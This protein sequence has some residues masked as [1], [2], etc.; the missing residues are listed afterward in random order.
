MNDSSLL[1]ATSAR[2]SSSY[3]VKRFLLI[4]IGMSAVVL[5]IA[6]AVPHQRARAVITETTNYVGDEKL[7]VMF[8]RDD[9]RPLALASADFDEDGTP[10]LVGGYGVG[11]Q[12]AVV[13]YRGNADAIYP[14]STEA[15]KR[16]A[17]GS[18]TDAPFLSPGSIFAVETAVDFLGAGD[19]DA[20]GHW[21]VVAATRGANVLRWLPG[22]GR[23]GFGE[24][25]KV[26]LAGGVTALIANDINRVDGLTDVV[27][28]TAGRRGAQALVFEN[29]NGAFN[30]EPEIINFPAPAASFACG[31]LDDEYTTDIAIAAGNNL[32][33]VYG[34]D[35]KLSLDAAARASVGAA[36]MGRREFPT[37]IKSLSIGAFTGGVR[38]DIAVLNGDGEVQILS[39][40]SGVEDNPEAMDNLSAWRTTSFA[41]G[42]GVANL[43]R[44]RV[45]GAAVDNLI[46]PDELNHQVSVLGFGELKT[47]RDGNNVAPVDVVRQSI[48]TIKLDNS[49]SA[50]LAMRLNTDALDDLVFLQSGRSAPT[51][52]LTNDAGSNAGS[53]AESVDDNQS[54]LSLR[55]GVGDVKSSFVVAAKDVD[56]PKLKAK[57]SD[58]TKSQM[59][60]GNDCPTT[61]IRTGQPINGTLTATDCVFPDGSRFD[62]YTFG[63]IANQRII[64][65]MSST[66]FDT[67]LILEAP[68]GSTLVEDDDGGG[69]TNSRIPADEGFF[70]LPSNG[71]YKIFANSF[72][73]GVTG[74]YT[75]RLISD[76]PSGCA[77]SPINFGQTMTGTLA[78]TDCVLLPGT[79][80]G[81][82]YDAYTFNGASGQRIAV[83]MSSSNFDTFLYLV[84]PDNTF[85]AEDNDGGGGTNSRIPAGSGFFT[86][87][88]N[89][90]Y[91]IFAASRLANSTGSYTLTLT[92][93][94]T[95]MLPTVVTNINDAG[96]GS[97]REAILNSNSNQGVD[98]IRFQIGSGIRTITP[99][100]PLPQITDAVTIDATTQ[101][102]F[103]GSPLIEL[104]GSQAGA[105]ASGFVITA[106]NSVVRGFV[107]NSFGANG[108]EISGGGGNIIEG[109]FIG[110]NTDSEA[111]FEF[112]PNSGSG[113]LIS[114]S[115]ANIIGGTTANARNVI[116]GNLGDGVQINNRGATENV[117]RGNFIGTNV[118]GDERYGNAV[119]GVSLLDAPNNIIG[120]TVAGSRNIISFNG[121]GDASIGANGVSLQSSGAEGNLIQGNLVGTDITGTLVFGNLGSGVFSSGASN[122]LIGGTTPTARNLISSNGFS[123]IGFQLDSNGDRVQGNFI[124]T[125]MNGMGSLSNQL[126]GITVFNADNLA[127]GGTTPAARNVISGNEY[128]GIFIYGGD[129]NNDVG[130]SVDNQIMGNYIGVAAN[131]SQALGN[132]G[133]GVL[134]VSIDAEANNTVGGDTVDARNIISGNTGTGVHIGILMVDPEVMLPGGGATGVS[135]R[136]NF[137]GMD[138]SGNE[139]LGNGENGILV[140]ADSFTNFIQD[141]V[142]ACNNRNGVEIPANR[143]PAVRILIDRNNI[144]DNAEL[145]IDLGESGVTPNDSLDTDTG[146]NFLQNFPVLT[147]VSAPIAN[148]SARHNKVDNPLP[149][150]T[151]PV[152]PAGGITVN[153]TLNSTPNTSYTVHWYFSAATQCVNNQ[154]V[155]R[156][157]VSG[158]VANVQT[159]GQGNAPFS[160][161][162][163]FP[164]GVLNGTVNCTAT[165]PEGNTSEFS[166]CLS[167]PPPSLSVTD[168]SIL[169]G[170]NGTT[171]LA[172]PVTLSAVDNE[173]VTVAFST[174]DGTAQAGSDFVSASST[175]TFN[176]GE[177]TKTVT[178]AING[179]IL[180][181][182]NET[183]RLILTNPVGASLGKSEAVGTIRNDDAKRRVTGLG[184]RPRSR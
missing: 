155:S 89:G 141:N 107:I 75:L 152:K 36:R 47:K 86:L 153:G 38:N 181:E 135:V 161:P 12:G 56:K 176:S 8:E 164:V 158:R 184:R 108:I 106:G 29:P 147:S 20:D 42:A 30:G 55:R 113:V 105:T 170:N 115:R 71:T 144:F 31:Q 9:V 128:A 126:G 173:T 54:S 74:N 34:R 82:F 182:P 7:K 97:L 180:Y 6:S 177:T 11:E 183:F 48:S 99:A 92:L 140:E 25:R 18:D 120:G 78:T 77:T 43:A 127:L 59:P 100:S 160:F 133:F 15:R 40:T 49:P 166:A 45:S 41:Q 84:A 37:A 66:A 159:D 112:F 156:P 169:E 46:L 174:V 39:R 68:D 87:P 91:R 117:L 27:V 118:R 114:D 138:A 172:F 95:S 154:A 119:N 139:P 109:N 171:T 145:G 65:E 123:G 5:V 165:D 44:G 14:N 81:A 151:H 3:R 88:S 76:S 4:G 110:T 61:P 102:G 69:G 122:N 149:F 58:I 10:D 148:N 93:P 104:D 50:M 162:F 129:T 73:S 21:D 2:Q 163:A 60:L 131:G 168:A 178:V 32:F 157:L 96:G 143:N 132:I 124:G 70:T 24:M 80:S 94:V 1:K 167:L 142:I 111:D 83:G 175:L 72:A 52:G 33:V 125:T 16:K 179:D 146:A 23:G 13:L 121:E 26:N 57:L 103:A 90:T 116:T 63:G 101:P 150:A 98:T 22:D 134:V 62:A 17:E 53:N 79:G 136:N 19:F 64:V 67:F 35:R 137:I 51:V 130:A 85:I 28:G